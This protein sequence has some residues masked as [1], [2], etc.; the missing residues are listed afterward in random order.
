MVGALLH[1]QLPHSRSANAA[2]KVKSAGLFG[3]GQ[4]LAVE[5]TRAVR[6]GESIVMDYGPDK[7]DN[8]LLLDHGVLDASQLKVSRTVARPAA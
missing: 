7:L 6:K 5:A 3:K 8:A 4:V 2:W 1:L